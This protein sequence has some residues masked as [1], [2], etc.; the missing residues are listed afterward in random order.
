MTRASLLASLLVTF[1]AG[2]W[3]A[4]TSSPVAPREPA[5]EA[6]GPAR[7]LTAS[8]VRNSASSGALK[9]QE[10]K[11][12]I[13]NDESF[14]TKLDAIEGA[15]SGETVRMVY[16]IWSKDESSSYFTD[17]IVQKA[18]EGVKFR[19]LVDLITNYANL[20]LFRWMEREGQ[21]NIEVRLFGRPSEYVIRDALFMTRPC[22]APK[23]K[24]PSAKECSNYKWGQILSEMPKNNPRAQREHTDF[25]SGLFLAAI[26]G[27]SAPAGKIALNYGQQLSQMQSQTGE[28]T[29]K[30]REELR[31]LMKLVLDAKVF[32]DDGAYL[33]LGLAMTLYASDVNP[34]LNQIYGRFPFEQPEVP[35][36]E[37][38]KDKLKEESFSHWEHITDYTH[39]KLLTVG[40]R[41]FQLGGRNIENSYH[42]KLNTL[43]KK[44]T[45][46]DTDFV[47]T[48]SSG[49]SQITKSFDALWD[50]TDVV[51]GASQ[52]GKFLNNDMAANPGSLMY[53]AGVCEKQGHGK[54]RAGMASC[55]QASYKLLTQDIPE[56]KDANGKVVV[57]AMGRY[58]NETERMDA[59]GVATRANKAKYETDYLKGRTLADVT[60]SIQSY[61]SRDAYNVVSGTDSNLSNND[62]NA[63]IYYVENLPW[64]RASNKSRTLNFDNFQEHFNN[65]NIHHLWL[66]SMENA[67]AVSAKSGRETEIILHS[68]YWFPPTNMLKTFRKMMDGTWD[69]SKVSVKIVTNSFQTTD[70]NVLNVF[71]RYQMHAFY[72][73]YDNLRKEFGAKSKKAADFHYYEYK[74]GAGTDASKVLSLHT[75]LSVIGDDLIIGS[76]NADIRSFM[77]DTNNGVFIHNAP[78][79]AGEYRRW[80]ASILPAKGQT[81]T[82]WTKEI[83]NQFRLPLGR[84]D[85]FS[86][87][88]NVLATYASG[89]P[90]STGSLRGDDMCFMEALALRFNFLGNLKKNKPD[91][92]LAM[93]QLQKA[94]AT[95]IYGDIIAIMSEQEWEGYVP[96][97][98]SSQHRHMQRKKEAM[99]KAIGNDFNR[100]YQVF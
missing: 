76:A 77:M 67:C 62:L 33:K 78:D 93:K 96:P 21:G 2:T 58:L 14:K 87:P 60:G 30:Q 50:Y 6:R 73:V 85:N 71:A 48:V 65:K 69:C 79:L 98:G 55:L 27:R 9:L 34:V 51:V 16:Y 72:Q 13:D 43:S 22:P 47:G 63:G 45:F 80:M 52:V 100:K 29:P 28:V 83:S 8:D 31:K 92:W 18:K 90:G 56:Q 94:I 12:V 3:I 11:L 36:L 39:H 54:N 64:T 46:I 49:G 7:L 75:K 68:A 37:K 5:Q 88:G 97:V 61:K 99:Q 42:M 24:V 66:R 59:I 38:G 40:E 95:D 1:A 17:K 10:A 20:D 74:P 84:E 15:Q 19:I 70:L 89:N 91:D 86:C 32:G 57:P 26:Y 44:Y 4:C 23:S 25:Y 35:F 41:F 81:E 82:R 53:A